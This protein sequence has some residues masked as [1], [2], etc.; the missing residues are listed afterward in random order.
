MF[1]L[2]VCFGTYVILRGSTL[3][4]PQGMATHFADLW[5]SM[6]GRGPRRNNATTPLARLSAGFHSLPP[7]LMSI[8]G[9]SGADSWVGGFVCLLG[10]CWSL[11]QTLPWGWEFLPLPPQLPQMF[12]EALRLNFPVLEPWVAQ[13]VSIPSCSSQ[14][15]CMWMWD[16]SV[17]NL[18]PCWVCQLPL[19][20]PATA[21]P[22]VL[23]TWLPI[24]APPTGLDECFFFNS[25][26][27]GLPYSS[28][29]CLFWLFFVF[30]FSVFLLLVVQG[31]TVYLPT[32][33]T[34]LQVNQ[35]RI[36]FIFKI[37]LNSESYLALVFIVFWHWF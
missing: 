5:C 34:W 12:S 28:I 32:P 33:L 1:F 17:P 15:I 9:P 30:K 11:Q 31:G 20:P 19:G 23:S 4:I 22:W 16:H 26:V 8:L 3:C 25:F 13:S 14:F 2:F 21:L 37:L 24:S 27:V 6:W 10:A 18:P 36:F 29:F 7:L 35:K